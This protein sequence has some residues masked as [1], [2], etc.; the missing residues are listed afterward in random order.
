MRARGNADAFF[1]LGEADEDHFR[2]LFGHAD[3]VHQ[4]GFGKRRAQA[5][6]AAFERSVDDTRIGLGDR[7]RKSSL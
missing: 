1:F 2:I 6:A 4:P 3:Q 7:H 5:D